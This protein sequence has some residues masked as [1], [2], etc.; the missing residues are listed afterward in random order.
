MPEIEQSYTRDI[1][2]LFS[3]LRDKLW[4]LFYGHL[5]YLDKK[6]EVYKNM[7]SLYSYVSFSIDRDVLKKWRSDI[8][9]IAYLYYFAFG[10][11]MKF[12]ATDEDTL[13]RYSY[14]IAA[15]M[16]EVSPNWVKSNFI[17]N[18]EA[19]RDTC[20]LAATNAKH[21]VNKF[22]MFKNKS[23]FES[24]NYHYDMHYR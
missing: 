14:D 19:S 16:L 21:G 7:V 17:N 24:L 12:G 15:K 4:V 18:F 2:G 10:L 9:V 3:K 23:A 6:E 22:I 11:L 20:D 1:F 5:N 8:Y 13:S